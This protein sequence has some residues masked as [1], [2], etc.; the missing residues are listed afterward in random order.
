MIECILVRRDYRLRD[1]GV[2]TGRMTCIE[3]GYEITDGQ[4][5]IKGDP[6]ISEHIEHAFIFPGAWQAWRW[7]DRMLPHP[8]WPLK[9]IE[10]MSWDVRPIGDFHF[11]EV[12]P[13]RTIGRHD[14]QANHDALI[15]AREWT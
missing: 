11:G 14:N 2:F 5:T 6:E 7:A 13:W 3:S 8:D 15:A 4:F 9:R 10:F 12:R 1:V